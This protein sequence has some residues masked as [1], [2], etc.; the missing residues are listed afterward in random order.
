MEK[1]KTNILILFLLLFI[2]SLD[3][4]AQTKDGKIVDVPVVKLFDKTYYRYDVKPRESLYSICKK[5]KVTEAEILSMNPYIIDGIKAGQTLMIP[6]KISSV[7]EQKEILISNDTTKKIISVEKKRKKTLFISNNRPRV[8]VFLPFS[9]SPTPGANDRYIEF[10]E[11]FLLAV[12]SL[13]SLGLSF[14]VQTIESGDDT[15]GINQAILTGLLDNTDYCIGGT[16]PEQISQLAEWAKKNQRNLI[17]PFSSHIPELE[18]NPYLFQTNISH[19]YMNDRVSEYYVSLLEK[20]N[21]VF[22]SSNT[23]NTEVNT[24]LILR[25]KKGLQNKNISYSEVRDDELLESLS[26]ALVDNRENAIIPSSLILS[27]TNRL[28][29]RLGAFA[30]ANPQKK[31]TLIGYPEWQVMNKNYLKHLYKLNTYIYS[32]FY[33]DTQRQNVRDFQIQFNRSFGKNLLNTYPK[34]GMMGYDIA[35]YFIPRMVFERSENLE[36]LPI[37][38]YLQNEF[39]FGSKKP[40]SGMF[41]K[42]FYIIHYTPDNA[43]EV[44]SFF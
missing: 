39:Q 25:I 33:A 20:S 1:N 19:A 10:Y 34:Y 41:N 26:K 29:T 9:S 36:N 40:N 37:M 38:G 21:I 27:E 13:K 11:G 4:I 30:N 28:V 7:S 14:E 18:N 24:S 35:A 43:V 42:V 15:D 44:K 5:F 8:T 2:I 6:V 16:S 31:I 3:V 23:D 22:L 12:D 17:L 32:S